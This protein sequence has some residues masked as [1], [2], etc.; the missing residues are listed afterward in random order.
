MARP[1]FSIG[2]DLGTTNS[3]LAFLQQRDARVEVLEVP[4]WDTL[5][6]MARASTLPSFL[7]LPEEAVAAQL[8]RHIEG[9]S[10]WVAGRL[11][12][13]RASEVPGRVAHS[14]KSWLA[15]HA[16]DPLAPLLPWGSE[17]LSQD[18]KISPVRAS[19]LILGHLRHAWNVS[20]AS[21][22][23]AFDDQD[24]TITVPASFDAASQR[25]TL[26]AAEQAGIPG[27]VRLLEE[28]QAAFQC[29]LDRPDAAS[30]LRRIL[31][32][33]GSTSRYVLVIDIGGGTSDLSVFAMRGWGQ[34]SLPDIERIAVS[35]HILLGGDNMDL[36]LA[37]LAE[38]RL[39][40]ERGRLSSGQW[41]HLVASCRDLKERALAAGGA[42]DERFTVALPGPGSNLIAGAQSAVLT[43][44]E[45]E[46]LLL[47]GFF[48]FCDAQAR[49][50]RPR[51]GLREV[52]LPYAAD[53]AVTRHL[54]DFLRDR[55][56]V[57]AVL[58][59]GGVLTPRLLRDRLLDQI[60]RWQDGH[61]P[62]GL[63]NAEPDLAVARGAARAGELDQRG[64]ARIAA[65]AARAIF[66]EV[67]NAPKGMAATPPL[68][69]VLPRGAP[70]GTTYEIN[71]PVLTLRLDRLVRFQAYS[72]ARHE[73]CRVGDV[74][75][76]RE[77]EFHA[78]PPLETAAR[79]GETPQPRGE[80]SVPVRLSATLNMLGLLQ[81]SCD[82]L[83]P[84]LSRSW[85]L[86]FNLRGQE[87]GHED[88]PV[89]HAPRAAIGPN[90]ADEAVEAA[91]QHLRR[92]FAAT[93]GRGGKNSFNA[94]LKSLEAIL[95]LRRGEWNAPLLRALWPAL[96]ADARGSRL[97]VDQEEMWLGLAS[98]LLRPGFGV[99]GDDFRIDRLWT[100]RSAAGDT[101][102]K[103]IRLQEHLLWR[104]LAGGLARDRQEQLLAGSFDSLRTGKAPAEL[105]LLAG[106]L[107]RLSRETKEELVR[108]FLTIAVERARPREHPGPYLV[109]LGLLLNRTP[110]Y[111]GPEAVLPPDHVERAFAALR[112][113]DW[114]DPA[115]VEVQALFLRA[116]RVVDDRQ[117]DVPK[118]LRTQIAGKLE[119]AGVPPSRVARVRDFVP[120]GRSD[121]ASLYGEALPPGLMIAA[122]GN[123][124]ASDTR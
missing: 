81:I 34:G 45:I 64:A 120:V 114:S 30:E 47:E 111:A 100:L 71:E 22:G 39:S 46:R 69:C 2:I 42:G 40:G 31:A 3:A 35:E 94:E 122:D 91:R 60:A 48:P 72:S 85:P 66:L 121:R 103:R 19:A 41:D 59:N 17:E 53:S 52:G 25:L 77:G 124:T 36:A 117:L 116:S 28:P 62:A 10:E 108:L 70:P 24:I 54:A 8:R 98:F 90:A 101:V 86:E 89:G 16:I 83:D 74:L 110:L 26:T 106:A 57:D 67:Q 65:G 50:Y 82:S 68:I 109:A 14:A 104:R 37:H 115:L 13:R 75:A 99:Q 15:H 118:G 113:F 92:V 49:P 38:T 97:Q 79:T 43:R 18:R 107:E 102:V 21:E 105:V 6:S 7:Y 76:S 84:A 5:A 61:A 63:A 55:P 32:A 87:V 51:T 93:P 29:W 78:L 11:A 20:F 112:G 9:G 23:C 123:E 73:A 1:R 56:R 33:R 58:F 88:G 27:A 44:A 95:G 12:R 4:Q 119:N 80:R 96:E